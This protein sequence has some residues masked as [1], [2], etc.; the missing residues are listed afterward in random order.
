MPAIHDLLAAGD[1]VDYDTGKGAAL[2]NGKL[3]LDFVIPPSFRLGLLETVKNIG[4]VAA[5]SILAD[6]MRT[7]GRGAEVGYLAGALQEMAPGKY[8]DA[9]LAAARDLLKMPLASNPATP[10][11]KQDRDYLYGVLTS[12][13]DPTYAS[14]AQTQLLQPNG[15]VDAAATRYLQQT[16]GE[17]SLAVAV[18]AWDNPSIAA[19]GK[20]PLARLAL[21]YV[22]V[23]AAA[24]R[25][26]ENAINDQNLTKSDRRELIKD[27]SQAGFTNPKTP[28]ATD[29]PLIQNRL[30]LIQRLA[31]A[32]TDPAIVTAFTL[33]SRDLTKMAGLALQPPAPKK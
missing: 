25:V 29:L 6:A 2:K 21:A 15:K 10:L 14:Q 9:S 32:A 24:G 27:L 13:N 12:L 1:D 19:D 26:F 11:D 23:N 3:P 17:R 28:S 20:E 33:A 22:G 4:G 18:Q 31:P 16:M 8:R 7:T 30:A 5:E